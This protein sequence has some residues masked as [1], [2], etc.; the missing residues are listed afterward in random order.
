MGFIK[1]IS[2]KVIYQIEIVSQLFCVFGVGATYGWIES[3]YINTD[4]L[5]S[6]P[7]PFTGGHFSYYHLCLLILMLI[8]SF[9]LAL[10]HIQWLTSNKKWYVLWICLANLPF[11]LMIEDIFFFLVRLQPIKI[12]EWTNI[13]PGWAFNFGFTYIPYWY[14]VVV[15]FSLISYAVANYNLNKGYDKKGINYI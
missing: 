12:D 11:S 4:K 3:I 6:A 14:F 9:N 7:I 2:D 5:V 8:V 13:K 10:S 15:I 1:N